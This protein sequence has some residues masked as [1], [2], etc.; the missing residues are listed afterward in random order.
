MMGLRLVDAIALAVACSACVDPLTTKPVSS[1][2]WELRN[3]EAYGETAVGLPP[4]TTLAWNLV[5]AGDTARW[6]ECSAIDACG[7]TERTRPTSELL[8][9]E[10]VATTSVD[11]R[12]IDVLRLSLAPRPTYVVPYKRPTQ[13]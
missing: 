12:E 6:R 8:G 1:P 2:A 10:R 7:Q 4:E 5:V 11:G 3:V 13:R 9:V